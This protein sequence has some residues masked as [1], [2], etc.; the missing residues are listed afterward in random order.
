MV[1]PANTKNNRR[2]H[3]GTF[4]IVTKINKIYHWPAMQTE[5][6]QL[7]GKRMIAETG[8]TE[9]PALSVD[10]REKSRPDGKRIMAETRFIG[11]PALYGNP[12][13]GISKSAS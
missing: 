4:A 7:E 13:A 12:R 8:F 1:R 11:F 6:S 2:I 3:L 5:K 10:P 9:F